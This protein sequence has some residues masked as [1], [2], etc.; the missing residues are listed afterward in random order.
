[1][2]DVTTRKI[3]FSI[4]ILGLL[5]LTSQLLVSNVAAQELGPQSTAFHTIGLHANGKVYTWGYNAKGQLGD[6][7]TT[8]RNYPVNA[9]D[10]GGGDF[11]LPVELSSFSATTSGDKVIIRW[12]TESENNNVGFSIYRSEVENGK[13][14]QIGFVNGAGN[15]ATFSDYIFTDTKVESGK[16]YYYYLEDVDVAGVRSK[17]ITI[18]VV[19]P[20]KLAEAIPKEFRLLQNY[21]NPFNPETWIPYDIAED[22]TVNIYIYNIQGQL[23]RHLNIGTQVAGSYTTKDRCAYWDGKDELGQKVSSGIYWYKLHAGDFEATQR[24]VIVK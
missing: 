4:I 10:S 17:N 11:S 23:V 5:A 12:R 9:Q 13:Y 22:V 20:I 15:T 1:M 21:P 18:K 16:T 7:T 14:T 24:M 8:Q 3:H 2:K 19:V 6:G